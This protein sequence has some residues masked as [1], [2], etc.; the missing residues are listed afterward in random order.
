MSLSETLPSGKGLQWLCGWE[1]TATG[2]GTWAFILTTER[3][4]FSNILKTGTKAV[5]SENRCERCVE[6]SWS[7]EHRAA[8]WEPG[9]S[10][11]QGGSPVWW[12]DPL[13][14]GE[15]SPEGQTEAQL[16]WRPSS[17][18]LP[19][20]MTVSLPPEPI[21]TSTDNSSPCPLQLFL[22][23]NSP[24]SCTGYMH[25]RQDSVQS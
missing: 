22:E 6:I 13:L 11:W 14:H 12:M 24:W 7:R 21:S 23:Q 8:G 20:N 16:H 15:A 4:S 25:R 19:P 9:L 1:C 2:C 18:H 10:S 5:E 17:L 3:C